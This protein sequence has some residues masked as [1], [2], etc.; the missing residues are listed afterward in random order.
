MINLKKGQGIN[1]K[2]ENTNEGLKN[3]TLGLGWKSGVKSKGLLGSLFGSVVN[4]DVDL[5]SGIVMY[6]D[7]SYVGTCY[8]GNKIIR[9]NGDKIIYH[10]GDDTTGRNKMTSTDNEQ[11]EIFLSKIDISKINKMYLIMNV[12]SSGITLDQI[13]KAYVNVYDDE[14]KVIATYNLSDDYKNKNGVIIGRVEY[15]NN[16][17]WKFFADGTGKNISRIQNFRL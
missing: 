4:R 7:D 12:F 8:Y 14:N 11:I 1:L 17:G 15:T 10:H 3:I 5:D 9:Y 6:K 16:E 2:K 13:Q